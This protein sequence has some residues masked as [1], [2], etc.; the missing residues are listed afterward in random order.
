MLNIAGITRESVNDGPGVRVVLYLQGC[1]H[2]CE[3]CQNPDTWDPDAGTQVSVDLL[4]ETLQTIV[5]PIHQGITFSGGEPFEQ[6]A[7]LVTLAN[8]IK[9]WELDLTIYTG[10]TL[11]GLQRLKSP[12]VND[13]LALA[14]Y[15][16]DGRFMLGARDIG[17]R[18]RGSKNQVVYKKEG[19]VFV[20]C[21]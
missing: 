21:T 11:A 17:L 15:L 20:V 14:D 2:R 7:T 12:P 18:W 6:A 19:G 4:A 16:I 3:G 9:S 8:Q 10:Y 13:L 1:P 5:T